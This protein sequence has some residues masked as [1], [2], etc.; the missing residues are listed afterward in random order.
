MRVKEAHRSAAS[1]QVKG[2]RC[3]ERRALVLLA[4]SYKTQKGLHPHDSFFE[5]TARLKDPEFV[6]PMQ[7]MRNK[8]QAS[9]P[10]KGALFQLENAP[11]PEEKGHPRTC[12]CPAQFNLY[13][14]D[15][16][17]PAQFNLSLSTWAPLLSHNR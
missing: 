12:E 4:G 8:Q 13:P 6:R 10:L 16:K 1:L 14:L 3:W 15:C 11:Q 17:C 7:D 5:H 2:H 9:A